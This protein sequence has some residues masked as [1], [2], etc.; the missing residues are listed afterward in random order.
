M[1]SWLK[2]ERQSVAMALAEY[3]HH[4]SRRQMRARAREGEV[5]EK[6]DGLRAHNRPLSGTRPEPVEEMSEPQVG[7]TLRGCPGASHGGGVAG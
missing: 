6:H 2:R 1:R 7:V 3:T 4:A 5:H